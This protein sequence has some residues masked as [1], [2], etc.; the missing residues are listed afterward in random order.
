MKNEKEELKIADKLVIDYYHHNI[1]TLDELHDKLRKLFN[2]NKEAVEWFADNDER[3]RKENQKET[4]LL[5]SSKYSVLVDR[6]EEVQKEIEEIKDLDVGNFPRF[7]NG[8]DLEDVIED[9]KDVLIDRCNE[10]YNEKL[11]N[12]DEEEE[13]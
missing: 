8:D 5:I 7:L 1:K 2:S 6:L 4:N 9:M 3:L 11:P 12:E 10:V 13:M